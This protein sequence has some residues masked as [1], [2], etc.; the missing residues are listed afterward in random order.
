[1]ITITMSMQVYTLVHKLISNSTDIAD[2]K[3]VTLVIGEIHIKEELFYDKHEGSLLILEMSTIS[4]LNW[5][6]H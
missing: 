3:Y 5:K 6:Q 1:M 4:Y 2:H